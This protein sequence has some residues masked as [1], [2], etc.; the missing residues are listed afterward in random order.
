[1]STGSEPELLERPRR[2]FYQRHE[3]LMLGGTAVVVG[4]VAWQALWSAG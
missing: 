2:S 3:R 4:L 1:M